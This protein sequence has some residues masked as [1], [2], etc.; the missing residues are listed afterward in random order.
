MAASTMKIVTAILQL[1]IPLF[2][3][4]DQLEA[5][6]EISMTDN[7]LSD[8]YEVFHDPGGIIK[9]YGTYDNTF[10]TF[11]CQV[12]IVSRKSN[13]RY[14]LR[15]ENFD[16]YSIDGQCKDHSLQIYDGYDRSA[17]PLTSRPEGLCLPRHDSSL[18]YLP[19][20]IHTTK[21][22]VTLYL[23]RYFPP[24][25]SNFRIIFTA[26]QTKYDKKCFRCV[27]NTAMCIDEEL[28]CDSLRHC[29]DGSDESSEGKGGCAES[30]GIFTGVSF[31]VMISIVVIV[32]V[33]LIMIGIGLCVYRCRRE[34]KT[35]RHTS[36]AIYKPTTNVDYARAANSQATR[37][38]YTTAEPDY[39]L[40]QTP[41]GYPSQI[42]S[43]SELGTPQQSSSRMSCT[44]DQDD[45]FTPL[46]TDTMS[47]RT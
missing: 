46:K 11:D 20:P 19:R 35:P 30:T 23:Y 47:T 28:K 33:I 4:L 40:A 6:S 2:L 26:Y 15:F 16:V 7:W 1:L 25:P 41:A 31:A 44:T 42:K 5:Y 37:A 36:N 38:L 14:E 24:G 34:P 45:V 10:G 8:C 18:W 17:P 21:E 22:A 29:T 32:V 9:A 43:G 3:Q 12:T 39:A 27:N 13:Q